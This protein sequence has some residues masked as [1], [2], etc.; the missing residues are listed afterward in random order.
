MNADYE[1]LTA[2]VKAMYGKRLR[3]DDFMRM[4]RMA[5]VDEVYADLRQNPVWGPGVARLSEASR[6]GRAKLEAALRNQIREEYVRLS[7]FIPRRDKA[8]MEFPVL[9][10]ELDGLLFTL[11]RLRA[12]R[13][14]EP[15]P[16]PTSFIRHSRTDEDALTRCTDYEG[17]LEAVRKSIF[18]EPLA[19]L[20]PPP[21]KLPDYTLVESALFTVY[22]DHFMNTVEKRYEGDAKVLLRRGIGTQVDMLNL[23]HI[24]RIK[25]FFPEEDGFIKILFPSYYKLK[26]AQ[27]RELCAAPDLASAM[28]VAS[29]TPYGKYFQNASVEDLGRLYDEYLFRFSRRQLMQGRPS[30]YVAVAFLNLRELELKELITVVETVKYQA[31]YDGRFAALLGK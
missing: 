16:L 10:S 1:A 12:G 7:A 2:K 14:T 27:I 30:I 31:P 5:S 20:R 24:L 8:L 29:Q 23:M 9:R 26:P 11:T 22:Y 19:R 18:Y 15:E 13:V 25:R 4:A 3:R 21:G 17:L 6:F 28:A